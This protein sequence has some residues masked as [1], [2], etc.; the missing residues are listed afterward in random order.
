MQRERLKYEDL[1]I[2]TSHICKNDFSLMFRRVEETIDRV[3]PIC[4]S[5]CVPVLVDAGCQIEIISVKNWNTE[6]FG[7]GKIVSRQMLICA[8]ETIGKSIMIARV[9]LSVYRNHRFL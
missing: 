5:G 6:R 1:W 9:H 8:F 3:K 2:A 7:C 4:Q